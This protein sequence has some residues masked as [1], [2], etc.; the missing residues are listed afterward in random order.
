MEINI[1]KIM[2]EVGK[3]FFMCADLTDAKKESE[4]VFNKTCGE[5]NKQYD[6]IKDMIIKFKNQEN[7]V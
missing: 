5:A 6:K 7:I 1:D 4:Q 2:S 3:Y